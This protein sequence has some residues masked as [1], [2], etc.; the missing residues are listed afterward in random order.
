MRTAFT[1]ASVL[2][3]SAG[4]VAPGASVALSGFDQ[5]ARI[6]MLGGSVT[7]IGGTNPGGAMAN[8]ASFAGTVSTTTGVNV[9]MP[10]WKFLSSVISLS[11][12]GPQ[13][14][15]NA[16]AILTGSPTDL[17][18]TL[19][20]AGGP[21]GTAGDGSFGM[22]QGDTFTASFGQVITALAGV[23]TDIF[24]FTNTDTTTTGRFFVDILLNGTVVD[25]LGV[26]PS[27]GGAAG[28]GFGGILIDV[29][30]GKQFNQIRVTST[31]DVLEI[32]AIAAFCI[33][34]PAAA[35]VGAAGLGL[36]AGL[37][38]RRTA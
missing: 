36:V 17:T 37:R 20:G 18:Y 38:R 6:N 27:T 25:S 26:T 10:N 15:G 29:V 3:F 32:D 14:V 21:D 12:V 11:D 31:K 4:G 28:S 9:S 8:G 30:D 16:A 35:G 2:A 13:Q 19:P 34:T 1:L 5:V 33:P 22:T 7:Q 23:T 24:L